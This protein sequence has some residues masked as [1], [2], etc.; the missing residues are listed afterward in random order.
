MQMIKVYPSRNRGNPWV[1]IPWTK[2]LTHHKEVTKMQYFIGIDG[3]GTSSRLVAIN[4]KNEVIARAEGGT[5]NITAQS[6]EG[7]YTNMQA[8][9][10]KLHTTASLPP[11]KCQ[12]LCIGSAGASTGENA[13]LLEKIFTSLGIKGKI[14]I[15]NDAELVLMTATGGNP[16]IIIISGTGSVGYAIDNNG[17]T[18]R[19]GGWGHLIDDG[20]SGYRI[21]MDAIKAALMDTDG[22]GKKTILTNIVTQF[23]N[24]PDPTK[25]L[26]YIYGNTFHKSHIAE[27]APLVEKA[28][29]QN[30]SIAISIQA[31]AAKD[32]VSLTTALIHR[33]QLFA[34]TIVL[35]GSIILR[36]KDIRQ[37]YETAICKSHPNMQ[38]KPMSESAELGAANIARKLCHKFS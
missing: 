24:Q 30:D 17:T 33:S 22:R 5:T 23:F 16:G 1:L 10:N 35:S 29:S 36:S 2:A 38:I 26:A 31:N 21:G 32:L 15:M 14:K 19:A 12:A 9:L 3:G 11:E 7:V 6:Y 28:A 8:L 18:H 20:G 25:T 4:E 37:M 27:L 34:H 13:S